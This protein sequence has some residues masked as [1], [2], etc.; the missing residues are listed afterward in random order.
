M[1]ALVS[2]DDKTTIQSDRYTELHGSV[3]PDNR[4]DLR[5]ARRPD[6]QGNDRASRPGPRDDHGAR[7]AVR[8]LTHRHQKA[9]A[10]ARGRRSRHDREGRSRA[11]V[12]PVAAAAGRRRGVDGDLQANAGRAPR[13]ARGAARTNERRPPMT[14]AT[15]STPTDREIHVERMFD[16]PRERVFAAM[17]DPDLISQWWGPHGT[18]TVVDQL[19]ARSGG[20]WRFVIRDSGGSEQGFRGTF[21]EVTPP[22][23]LVLTFEWEG[24]PATSPWTPSSSRTSATRRGYGRRPSSTPPRSATACSSRGWRVG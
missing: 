18:T 20:S 2:V 16:A 14:D 5:G 1:R 21:R 4:P 22:E 17:T 10:G 8:D 23:R 9:R 24:M 13:P 7:G 6:S 12:Q 3:F 15:L 11:Q 19:D